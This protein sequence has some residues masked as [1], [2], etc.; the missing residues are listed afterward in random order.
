MGGVCNTHGTKHKCVEVWLENLK[1]NNLEDLDLDRR[2]ILK[3]IIS[4]MGGRRL[5]EISPE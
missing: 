3:S 4:T 2:I 5:G 1:E